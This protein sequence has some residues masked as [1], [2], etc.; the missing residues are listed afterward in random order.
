VLLYHT[1]WLADCCGVITAW[2]VRPG[3]DGDLD[4]QTFNLIDPDNGLVNMRDSITETGAVT[5]LYHF[6]LRYLY[7]TAFIAYTS[8]SIIATD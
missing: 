8:C 6:K 2:E 4:L 3:I 1:S 7:I 5:L